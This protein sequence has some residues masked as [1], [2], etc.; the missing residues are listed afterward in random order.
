M[1]KLVARLENPIDNILIDL[2][3]SM[4][5]ALKATGHTPNMITT[6]GV[7]AG[8][9]S[10]VALWNDHVGTFAAL[11]ALRVFLDDADGHFAR[12]YGM[13]TAFGDLYDHANDMASMIGLLVIVHKKYVV[14]P[15]LMVGFALLMLASLVQLGCQQRICGSGGK[16]G[17]ETLDTLT[18]A[19]PDVRAIHVTRWLSHGSMHVYIIAAVW[20]M[21]KYC[22]RRGRD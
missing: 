21:D 6:Y 16:N 12:K 5:P 13:E 14:P 8:A 19:C 4:C 10:L 9:L 22:P 17:G 1:R 18:K 3:D 15:V 20:Y 11:W 2:A 7:T